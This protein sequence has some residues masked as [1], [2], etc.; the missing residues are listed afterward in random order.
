MN[1]SSS[2]PSPIADEN[3]D[4]VDSFSIGRRLL[5]GLL[6]EGAL[7]GSSALPRLV[8][9]I[10]NIMASVM[11]MALVAGLLAVYS[12]TLSLTVMLV[13]R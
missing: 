6:I 5:H 3:E 11:G 7:Y 12:L 10:S 8:S 1:I 13:R 2:R 9:N 4:S